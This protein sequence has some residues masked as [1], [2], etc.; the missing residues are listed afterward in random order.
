MKKRISRTVPE[1]E[2]RSVPEINFFRGEFLKAR[3]NRFN[4]HA[5]QIHG[6]C[7]SCDEIDLS[8]LELPINIYSQLHSMYL[9][10]SPKKKRNGT[11]LNVQTSRRSEPENPLKS[12]CAKERFASNYTSLS[13]ENAGKTKEITSRT[14]AQ[15]VATRRSS[16][17]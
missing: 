4:F 5:K 13:R 11:Y 8:L 15:E 2:T 6:I 3:R 12:C 17:D 14:V 9:C 10:R 1:V 7:Q 16:R